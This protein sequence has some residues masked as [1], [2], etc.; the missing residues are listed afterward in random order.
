M[1]KAAAFLITITM[2]CALAGMAGA[3]T[4]FIQASVN[5][6][7][8]NQG[9]EVVYTVEVL[10]GG[11]RQLTPDIILPDFGG[12]FQP[13]EVY[14]SSK[15]TLL[16][17]KTY[18][19]NMKEAHL[20]VKAKG[21]V[22]IPPAI[23]EIIDPETKERDTRESN[24]VDITVN[25]STGAVAVATPTPVIDVLRPIKNSAH[26]TVT[27][28]LPYAIGVVVLGLVLGGMYYLK[29]RPAPAEA[30]PAEPVDPRTPEQRAMDDLEKAMA[31]KNEGKVN[32]FYTKLAAILRRFIAESHGVKAEEATS[33][34]ML[35]MMEKK[36]FKSEFLEKIKKYLQETDRVKFANA[37]PSADRLEAILP[38]TVELIK[39]P[40]KVE[41]EPEP[42]PPAPAPD[43]TPAEAA[44]AATGDAV[45]VPPDAPKSAAPATPKE[46]GTR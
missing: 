36:K 8:A 40:D 35:A 37:Q 3:A 17:G 20:I 11:E 18:I 2:A 9:D 23:V 22:T 26:V 7:T 34:E 42:E 29:H 25:E 39:A 31:L 6:T 30:P 33:R 44:E 45:T 15:I 4:E 16:N 24:P 27:Q 46:P 41:P 43:G 1:Y 5:P 38:E 13:G 28:W 14:S 12:Q 21:V 10:T 32:E 19:R